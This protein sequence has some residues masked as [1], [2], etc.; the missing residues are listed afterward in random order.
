M[1]NSILNDAVY[2]NLTN[3]CSDYIS[4]N[5]SDIPEKPIFLLLFFM[6]IISLVDYSIYPIYLCYKM[7]EVLLLKYEHY[8]VQDILML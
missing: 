1:Q 4:E 5:K 8:H 3:F 2:D 7:Y 6:I